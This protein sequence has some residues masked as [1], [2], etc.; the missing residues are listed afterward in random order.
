M[1]VIFKTNLFIWFSHFQ[2]Q[3]L[4]SYSWFMFLMFDWNLI[5]TTSN[6]EPREYLP[7]VQRFFFKSFGLLSKLARITSLLARLSLARTRGAGRGQRINLE[8]TD[9]RGVSANCIGLIIRSMLSRWR[10]EG[11]PT[12]A[13]RVIACLSVNT[14]D[15]G[16]SVYGVHYSTY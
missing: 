6:R 1:K 15:R 14:G 5:K 16:R 7:S 12:I 4:K 2:T 10:T 13:F 8:D 11:V 9:A 3:P